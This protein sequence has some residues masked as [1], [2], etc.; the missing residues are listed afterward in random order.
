[1]AYLLGEA[2][3]RISGNAQRLHAD[4]RS[5]V[6]KGKKN[7]V[8][9]PITGDSDSFDMTV[10]DVEDE[11]NELE[12]REVEIPVYF[13]IDQAS[14]EHVIRK[15]DELENRD[16]TVDVFYNVH[17]DYADMAVQDFI[18]KW[19]SDRG[20]KIKLPV[21]TDIKMPKMPKRFPGAIPNSAQQEMDEY[22][23]KFF[24]L[25]LIHI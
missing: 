9:I 6:E 20:R 11:I 25:S 22:F 8:E 13:Y 21:E 19:A 12:S 4:I 24:R 23:E 18:D 3:I 17:N 2:A 10:Q 15:I 1:M 14:H 5:A 7:Q 16:A